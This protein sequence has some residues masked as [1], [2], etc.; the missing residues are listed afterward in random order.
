[1]AEFNAARLTKL[2]REQ[3]WDQV[4]LA[5]RAGISTSVVSSLEG[6]KTLNPRGD[7]VTALA[8]VLGC[9]PSSLYKREPR[10]IAAPQ[11][12]EVRADAASLFDVPTDDTG[13]E[14]RYRDPATLD[15]LLHTLPYR[16]RILFDGCQQAGFT[17]EQSMKLV[18]TAIHAGV[19][20]A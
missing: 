10:I 14:V 9:R 5:R 8:N 18:T 3:G 13:P 2:R 1:M 15:E 4:T 17:D 7:T 16:W 6:G 20:P 19:L 11:Q 12:I